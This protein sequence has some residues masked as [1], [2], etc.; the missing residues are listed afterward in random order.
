MG[1]RGGCGRGRGGGRG[2]GR[3]PGRRAGRGT[4][5]G[6]AVA[7]IPPDAE[8]RDPPERERATR[9]AVAQ[10][11]QEV[12]TGCGVCVEACPVGAI[13]TEAGKAWVDAGAC[14]GCRACADACPTNA[15]G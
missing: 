12:C 7:R 14:V 4:G 8:T 13:R 6:G 3:G 2:G 10:V 15:I 11:D 9:A 5:S 1:R